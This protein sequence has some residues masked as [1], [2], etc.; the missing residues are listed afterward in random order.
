MYTSGNA[1]IIGSLT[2]GNQPIYGMNNI[3]LARGTV[4]LPQGGGNHTTDYLRIGYGFMACVDSGNFHFLTRSGSTSSIYARNVVSG[5]SLQPSLVSDVSALDKISEINV[6]NTS[7]GF[8]LIAPTNR[9]L[10]ENQVVTTSY[11][12]KTNQEEIQVDFNSAISTL[13]KAI[14]ELKEENNELKKLIKGVE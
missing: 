2:V 3:A 12:E 11:N 14:Q 8:R 4:Y 10:D 1:T 9:S 7:E 13:W 5:Y 6:V